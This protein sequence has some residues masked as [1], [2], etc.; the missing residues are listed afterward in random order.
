[1]QKK[2]II[3]IIFGLLFSAAQGDCT[4]PLQK[5]LSSNPSIDEAYSKEA[6]YHYSL[7]VLFRLNHELSEAIDQ[8]KKA[9][10]GVCLSEYRT[11]FALC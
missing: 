7:A 2:I 1:M 11:G 5:R 9:L 4:P 8:M 10:A 3:F 6:A